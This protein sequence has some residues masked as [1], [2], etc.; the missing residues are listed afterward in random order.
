MITSSPIVPLPSEALTPDFPLKLPRLLI[1]RD[2]RLGAALG[3]V[4]DDSP[5]PLLVVKG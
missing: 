1:A 2:P 4:M 3:L 5:L